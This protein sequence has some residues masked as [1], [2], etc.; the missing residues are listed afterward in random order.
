MAKFDTRNNNQIK[1]S[2]LGDS[3][4]V[5]FRPNSSGNLEKLFRSKEQQ[6]SFNFPYQCGTGADL[7][8]VAFDTEHE[9]QANDIMVM[10]SDG[11]FDNMYDDDIEACV[12]PEL[13]GTD[14]AGLQAASNCI[15]QTALKLGYKT[16]F[17][18]PFALHAKEHGVR[19]PN[20]GKDDDI[21]V[22]VSQI[23]DKGDKRYEPAQK[24]STNGIPTKAQQDKK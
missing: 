15:A 24:I 3:G 1:T 19:Y 23:H 2:N 4:Y 13:I 8:Y 14:L 10:A 21:V 9:I 17:V 12:K 6:F 18:S 20:K 16:G 11:V 22:I 5:L 7:P